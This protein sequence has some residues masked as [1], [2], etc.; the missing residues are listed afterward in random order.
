MSHKSEI[1]RTHNPKGWKVKKKRKGRK[2]PSPLVAS[3]CDLKVD[4]K[5]LGSLLYL[6][7]TFPNS[8]LPFSCNQGHQHLTLSAPRGW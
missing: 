2:E 5:I 1:I 4:P 7:A 8:L 6:L 3:D